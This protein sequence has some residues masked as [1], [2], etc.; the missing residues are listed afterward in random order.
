MSQACLSLT[1]SDLRGL[2]VAGCD[3]RFHCEAQLL[4]Q[5]TIVVIMMLFSCAEHVVWQNL[6]LLAQRHSGCYC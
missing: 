6:L 1:L 3:W 4:Q 2:C 5:P